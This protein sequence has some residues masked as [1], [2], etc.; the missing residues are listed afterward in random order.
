MAEKRVYKV[1]FSN[2]GTIY[3][4]YARNVHQGALYGFIEVEGLLFGENRPSWLIR[5]K[6]G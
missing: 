1:V 3:E 4:V 5:L 2:H 6:N